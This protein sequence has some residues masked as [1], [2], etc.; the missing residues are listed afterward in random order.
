MTD[1]TAADS[2]MSDTADASDTTSDTS[3]ENSE[4][5]KETIVEEPHIHTPSTLVDW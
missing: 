2:D 5:P 4:I 3:A 1:T